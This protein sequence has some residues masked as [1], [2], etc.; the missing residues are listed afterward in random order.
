[1]YEATHQLLARP[2][3]VKL[4]RSDYLGRVDTESAQSAIERFR[5]EATAAAML[6][7]PHT[8]ELYDF[9]PTGDG[10]FYFA[11]ERLEGD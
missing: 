9:G 7:S 11:M 6:R 10:S 1:V 4:I 2:V 5:R 3:A 8:I